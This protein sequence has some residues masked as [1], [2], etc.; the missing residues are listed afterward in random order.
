M[1]NLI[2][3]LSPIADAL[4]FSLHYVS[5]SGKVV[6]HRQLQVDLFNGVTLPVSLEVEASYLYPSHE[7]VGVLCKVAGSLHILLCYAGSTDAISAYILDAR[8]FTGGQNTLRKKVV[9]AG[10]LRGMVRGLA[11]G[12]AKAFIKKPLRQWTTFDLNK[13]KL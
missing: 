10:D 4:Q 3:L 11:P 5:R 12:I 1:K 7:Q 13:G 8:Q 6:G 2:G 9:G